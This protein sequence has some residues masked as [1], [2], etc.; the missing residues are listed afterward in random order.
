M[1]KYKNIV[2][3]GIQNK[4]FNLVIAAILL[5]LAAYT[6][7]IVYQSK[8]LTTLVNDTNKLQKDSIAAISRQ[9]MNGVLDASFTKSTQMQASL[10]NNYFGNA[11][12]V[13]RMIVDYA[14]NLYADPDSYTRRTVAP[15]VYGVRGGVCAQLLT[16]EGVDPS[17]P[18]IAEELGLIGNMVDMMY[19]LYQSADVDSCY[20]ALSSGV[21][22]LVDDHP[23]SKFDADGKLLPIPIR[24]RPW[25][26]GAEEKRGLY[27][28][29]V[30]KDLF[31]GEIS[32]MCAYPIYYH[33]RLVAVA[34]ADLFLNDMEAAIS[35]SGKNGS[36]ICIINENGHVVLSSRKEGGFSVLPD[37]QAQDLRST[38]NRELGL[39]IT[40]ALKEKTGICRVNM[41]ETSYY[42]AGAPIPVVNWAFVAM[43]P[44]E[45]MDQPTNAMLGQYDNIENQAVGRYR[46]GLSNAKRTIL[47]LVGVVF[48]ISAIATNILSKRIVKPLEA[49]TT[50]VRSLGGEDL[51]FFME[52]EYETGD[53]IEVLAESFAMLSA[54]TLQYVSEVKRITGEKERIGAELHMATEIQ[55][56]QLPRLFPPFPQRTEFDIFA[57]MDPAKEVGGDF[58]DF[59][60]VDD[61]HLALVMADVSGKGVPAALFMMVSRVLIKSHLQSG[62]SPGKALANVNAQLCES[63]SAGFFVTVWVA[64]MEISTGK[65]V[66]A[67]AGH[68]HPALRR[69]SEK[70]ELVVYRHSMAV[71]TMED[72]TFREHEFQLNPGDSLFVYTDGVSEATNAENELFGDQRI[73]AALNRNP[74]ASPAKTV[75]NVKNGIDDFVDGAEQFDDITMLCLKYYGPEKKQGREK[76]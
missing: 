10:A 19:G 34:G 28:T 43:V 59:F 65:G 60:L 70:Y 16:E 38:D 74:D 32:I 54:K 18:E 24:E 37:E 76:A 49:I 66:A 8:S 7:V 44:Q 26:R 42:M 3:G 6:I 68:E 75:E 11:E 35:S 25:Y 41:D 5:I 71:A 12:R 14:E 15:P 69:A 56:S 36:D 72:L 17:S 52:K 45:L 20:I 31:T 47:V 64:V 33:G 22:I 29:D 27:F 39:F 21:M 73:L 58:Y 40:T 4:I 30:T 55:A 9:T 51:Q 53:E 57:S 62:E 1:K 61:D 13:V 67:N 46:S 50:R 63:N 23:E 2:I 48:A